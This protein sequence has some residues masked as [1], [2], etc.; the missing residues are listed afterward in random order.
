MPRKRK[1]GAPLL[2]AIATLSAVLGAIIHKLWI[3]FGLSKHQSPPPPPNLPT[4]RREPCHDPPP[5]LSPLSPALP[6]PPLQPQ[7]H[8]PQTHQQQ[9]QQRQQQQQLFQT[10]ER[11][12]NADIIINS[13]VN[14]KRGGVAINIVTG[15]GPQNPGNF[16]AMVRLKSL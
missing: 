7:T 2:L 11:D 15:N 9:Q 14:E 1:K 12:G 13:R 3:S 6:P 16:V 4:P 8:Q 10:I 5:S